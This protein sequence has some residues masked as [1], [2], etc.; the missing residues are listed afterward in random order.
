MRAYQL[1]TRAVVTNPSFLMVWPHIWEWNIP[2]TGEEWAPLHIHFRDA[3][4]ELTH[5]N[6]GIK[7]TIIKKNAIS[8][9]Q[10]VSFKANFK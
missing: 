1:M 4:A 5:L 2:S 7:F 10:S 6:Y 8:Y 9:T 3:D